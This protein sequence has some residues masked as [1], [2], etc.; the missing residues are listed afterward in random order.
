MEPIQIVGAIFVAYIVVKEVFVLVKGETK[1]IAKDVDALKRALLDTGR[2]NR[3]PG[4]QVDEIYHTVKGVGRD[5]CYIRD[6]I[7]DLYKWHD[8]EDDDGVKIWYV[9]RSLEHSIKK[10]PLTLERQR[11]LM[12][13]MSTVFDRL[14]SDVLY[15][16]ECVE[17]LENKK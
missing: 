15:V 17:D 16:K 4:E 3:T 8:K 12:E 9:R 1:Q 7:E 11:E 6:R 5:V 14:Q 10:L 13:T 2:D